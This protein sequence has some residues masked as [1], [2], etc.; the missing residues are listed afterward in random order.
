MSYRFDQD[1]I[2]RGVIYESYVKF[3]LSSE[4]DQMI[5]ETRVNEKINDLVC[6]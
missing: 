5:V 1:N 3:I 6:W 4:D 2:C